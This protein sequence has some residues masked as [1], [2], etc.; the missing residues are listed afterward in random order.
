MM[1]S[2]RVGS[3]KF[4]MSGAYGSD[5]LTRDWANVKPE[6]QK[7]FT[8]V[9]ADITAIFWK[10]NGHNGAGKEAPVM[11]EFGKNLDR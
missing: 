3:Q 7:Y 9:P 8:K 11:R 5:G 1:G 6:N 2:I 10:G 4:P